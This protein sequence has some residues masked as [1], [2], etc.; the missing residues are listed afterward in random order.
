MDVN[1]ITHYFY[2]VFVEL[3]WD[4]STAKLINVIFNTTIILIATYIFNRI[5]RNIFKRILGVIARKTIS[6]FDD[7]LYHNKVFLNFEFE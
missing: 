3:G 2:K 5:L 6:Q 4:K 1:S 7:H